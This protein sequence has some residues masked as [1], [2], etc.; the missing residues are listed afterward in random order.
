MKGDGNFVL[1]SNSYVTLWNA[2]VETKLIQTIDKSVSQ[3]C[4]KL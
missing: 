1:D 2:K 4:G 3:T